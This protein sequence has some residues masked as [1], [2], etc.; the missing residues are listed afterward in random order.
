[1]K[2]LLMLLILFLFSCTPHTSLM[3]DKEK[4]VG[5]SELGSKIDS[6][7]ISEWHVG[8]HHAKELHKGFI[9]HVR[10][11]K[12]KVE[13]LK[14]VLRET[15]VDSWLIKLVKKSR[16]EEKELILLQVPYVGSFFRPGELKFETPEYAYINVYYTPAAVSS[17]VANLKCPIMNHRKLIDDYEIVKE[18]QN[19]NLI[20]GYNEL[21]SSTPVRNHILP[22]TVDGGASLIG[23]YEVYIALY[24]EKDKI[25]Y[26]DFLKIG[27]TLNILKEKEE[28]VRECDGFVPPTPESYDEKMKKFRMN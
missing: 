4:I 23:Q 25:R 22:E 7:Q 8:D 16:G 20:I 21:L 2:F 12:I 17:R 6:I 18:E 9:L 27:N 10:L 15:K 5:F 19:K 13:D 28:E 14:K 1:M 3:M 24:N 11:P 26:S